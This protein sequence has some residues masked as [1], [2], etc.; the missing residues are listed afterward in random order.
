MFAIVCLSSC[1]PTPTEAPP[2]DAD[3]AFGYLET[4]V[5]FGPRTPDTEASAVARDY[6][7]GH[8]SNLGMEVDSQVFDFFDPYS[9]TNM[10]LVNVIAHYVD[11]DAN[12]MRICLM[13]HYDCRPRAEYAVDST[14]RDT[15]IDGANDGASGVAIL[16]ELANMVATNPPGCH[17]DFVLVDGEDWGE[18]G[19]IQY[20]M[21]G[22]KHFAQSNIR[23]RYRFGIVVDMVGDSGQQIYR[24]GFSNMY[25]EALTD[26]VWNTAASLGVTTFHD[27]VKY[28]IYD[29]HLSLITA[30]VP[31][32]DIIDFDY[33]FWHTESDTP[34]KC[35]PLALDN[36]G[37]VLG[38][39]I[40]NSSSWP[41]KR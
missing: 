22:S 10:I 15:P 28:T 31:T 35:S 14:L 37:R 9:S 38:H 24:E 4:Q 26:L 33:P 30:G 6:Y 18:P 7:Y 16:M 19:D 20:Y 17:V 40:Y 3:R 11:P 13:A 39:V 12:A 34:D 32:I 8:F 2:F 1:G 29:D 5:D 21:L 23:D 25:N 27:S 41:P 36:V